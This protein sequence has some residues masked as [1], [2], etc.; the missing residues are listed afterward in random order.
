M[1][2]ENYS[3]EPVINEGVNEMSAEQPDFV[4]TRFISEVMREGG[5]EYPRKTL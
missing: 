4:L 5:Q 3:G 1:L 2:K